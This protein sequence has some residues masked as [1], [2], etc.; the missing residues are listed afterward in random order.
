DKDK[1]RVEAAAATRELACGFAELCLLCGVR[2]AFAVYDTRIGR[3][4]AQFA[5]RPRAVS[6]E[7]PI[8]ESLSRLGAFVMDQAMLFRLRAASGISGPLV[9]PSMLPPALQ[10]MAVKV[11][12]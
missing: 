9:T 11:A 3:V 7:F 8:G 4:L 10:D 6:P 12:S 1:N 2:E 5:C